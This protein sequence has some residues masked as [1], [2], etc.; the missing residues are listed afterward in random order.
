MAEKIVL[1]A[2]VKS[3]I[4]KQTKATEDWGK[5]I[6]DV[7]GEL[8]F[9]KKML[10]EMEKDLIALEKQQAKLTDY[11]NMLNKTTQKIKEQKLAL[12][13]QKMVVKDMTNQQ[14]DAN[15]ET[16]KFTQAQKDSNKESKE[17]VANF[18]FMG[19][20]LN[21]V[22][23]GFKQIIPTA[24]G[25][26]GT[27]RAGIMSTGIGALVLA[28]VA[29]MQSF[30][31][32][33]A[34][35]EKFQRIMAAIGAVTAQVLDAFA[36]LGETIIATFKDPM[37]AMKKFGEGM[38]K[39]LRDP[40]GATRDM[41]IQAAISASS[42]VDETKK[43]VDALIE[44]TNMRQKA[45]HIDRKLKIERAN[46]NREINDIRLKAEDREKFNATE[47]IA[48]LRKAQKIEE[49]ITKK[50]IKSKK[51]LVDA[52]KLEMKQGLNARE[53]KDKLAQ[54]QAELINLDTKKLRSQRLLQTQI[55]TA[56]NQERAEKEELAKQTQA[57]L[58][59]EIAKVQE[60]K[61][62]ETERIN[63]LT[64]TAAK[65]L[66]D[67]YQSQLDAEDREINAV[68]DKYFAIIEGKQALGEQV[69][70]LEEA[71]QAE[72]LAI[73][74]K[75]SKEIILTDDAVLKNKLQLTKAIGG[76]IGSLSGIF[77][78]G[79]ATAKAIALTEI[80]INTGVG[81]ANALRI[82]QQ[83][84][85]GTGVA[86]PYTTPIFYATQIAAVLSAAAQAKQI[87]GAG[88]GGDSAG[89]ISA[90][91]TPQAPA[92]QM[93]S[94]AFDLECGIE[95]EPIRAYVL[96]DEMSSSQAQ[97]ANIRRRATI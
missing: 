73:N 22:K 58:D 43:E 50:E 33:E 78:E 28:V 83:G 10:I 37:P 64:V 6:K 94:G 2:E 53:A 30:K 80:A 54:L 92:P 48:L 4:G 85:M 25:M 60:L 3:N 91:A 39:F 19:V 71:Q 89:N 7:S 46:A 24:K 77:E 11:E 93:M 52:Q 63:N 16:K 32:S 79:S 57:I 95:P 36:L 90:G 21:G 23:K 87:L 35:Q 62:A 51:L 41:F 5:S 20:S 31:R 40:T 17:S 72:I 15:S 67:Y 14:K 61:D 75:Y 27:I 97:L 49:D 8:G 29:L 56:V 47:R 66:D 82:A 9:Q 69:A 96:T 76:A 74:K 84:G 12:K 13:D 38:V 44:V 42:F 70:D 59:A 18:Q 45:H 81:F 65:L 55:T 86:A 68:Y 34:G 26:F 1:E 88:G